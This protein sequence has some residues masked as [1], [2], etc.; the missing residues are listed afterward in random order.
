MNEGEI[1]ALLEQYGAIKHGHF[2]LSSGMHSD[3]YVQ[4]ALVLS[5]PGIAE[6]L[7]HELGSAF[8]D[9]GVTLVLGPALGGVIIAHEVARFCGVPMVFAERVEGEMVLRRGFQIA[10]G[11][12]V[13]VAEDTVTTG[14]SQKEVIAL[15]RAAG[16]EVVG[17]AAIV[18]RAAGVSFGVP[19]RSLLR[20]D[21]Q[22]WDAPDCPLC[23]QGSEPVSPGSRHLVR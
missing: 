22:A 6:R 5:H 2:K 9:A 7:G 4:N 12:R 20:I 14:K 23:A 10:S 16:A 11:D 1:H 19:F 17:V 18:D 3:L 13:L 15:A 8:A 21:A